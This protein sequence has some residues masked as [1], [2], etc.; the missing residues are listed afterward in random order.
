MANTLLPVEEQNLTP[1]QVEQLDRRRNRGLLLMVISGQFGIIMTVLLLWLVQ[2]LTYAPGWAHP[3]AYY[4]FLA[5]IISGLTGAV[6]AYLRH[7]A[8]EF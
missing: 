4:F 7:G 6:G 5:L 3:I 1:H 2:D 8:P